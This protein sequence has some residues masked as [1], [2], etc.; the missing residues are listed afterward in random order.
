LVTLSKTAT[1]QWWYKGKLTN[2]P[3]LHDLFVGAALGV[4]LTPW[5]GFE[6]EYNQVKGD[7][8][9]LLC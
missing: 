3:E 9:G 8:D 6:A 2:G 5:L 4:E 7:V 1:Q